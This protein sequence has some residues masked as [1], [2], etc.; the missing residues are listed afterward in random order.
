M[1][2]KWQKAKVGKYD[3]SGGSLVRNGEFC[4]RCGPGVFLANHPDRKTCGR[5]GY[6]ANESASEAPSSS[7][8]EE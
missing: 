3:V 5:C 2:D 7:E 6:D 1:G 8:E 4:P